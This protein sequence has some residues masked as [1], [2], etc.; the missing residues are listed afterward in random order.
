MPNPVLIGAKLNMK[1]NSLTTVE[2]KLTELLA[3][4][5]ELEAS[6]DGIENE[7]DL[8]A[9][10]AS[11]KENDDAITTSEEEKTKLTEEI[12]ELEKELEASNRRSP[13]KGAKRNM[14]KHTE[15]REAINA[16]VRTKDQTRAG[17]TSVE[18]GA[19][20]PEELLKPQKELVDTVDLTQ[21]VRTVPVNRGSGKYPVIHKSNGKMAS[22]AELAKN[23]ELAHPTFTEVNYDIET[24]RGYIPVSQEAIDDADY[25]ITGLIAEDIKDQDLNTKN[26][27]IAAI[28]K[29]ATAKAVTGLD[30]IV[31]LLNTGF[32]QVYNVKFYVSSSLFNELDLLKD[33]NGRYLLQDDITVASGKRIKGKEVV[34]LDDD[35]IGT[36]AGDLVGFVGD[37]K[38]FCTLFNRK[39]AS[40]K[41]VDNDIYGQLL[42]GFVRFDAKAV[43]KK[44]GYYITFTPAATPPAG[45]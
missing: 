37:A 25:D 41:W 44:A 36:K 5:S 23:P 34:V 13:D 21:Y 43:D 18:G 27:K 35:I 16:Y 12:E 7:E 6:I 19:L 11:V 17:F 30:G 22:V 8:T 28:F 29:S 1:R 15:T 9:I 3:K 24:Y 33:K 39:Q 32:K 14:P 10:E 31:T 2:G 4:R 40:V 45:A 26:T 42:A 20:I 38:E